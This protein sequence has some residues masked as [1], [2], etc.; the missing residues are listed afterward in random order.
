MLNYRIQEA[1]FQMETFMELVQ[2]NVGSIKLDVDK[3]NFGEKPM[4][5]DRQ[6]HLQRLLPPRRW[7]TRTG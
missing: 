3:F 6:K 1:I 4:N 2:N 5:K 7:E